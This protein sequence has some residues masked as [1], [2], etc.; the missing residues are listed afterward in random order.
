MAVKR[1]TFSGID[2]G[3]DPEWLAE[4]TSIYSDSM[5]IEWGILLSNKNSRPR[6]PGDKWIESLGK[7]SRE[8]ELFLAGH[9][10]GKYA[11]D[12]VN[13]KLETE[14]D[15]GF[16]DRIQINFGPF[17]ELV[18]AENL[19]NSIVEQQQQDS[20]FILQAGKELDKT[21]EIARY[22]KKRLI[23]TSI[24]FDCSGGNGIEPQSWPQSLPDI[25]CGYAGG[26]APHN[27]ERQLQ[28]IYSAAG[29][30][31]FWIDMESGIR[32]HNLIDQDKII[33]VIN[34]SKRF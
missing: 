28:E 29:A 16:F 5:N 2:E 9:L 21:I 12:F 30:A 19:Y 27:L 32:T 11:R 13:G 7:L 14:I 20:H 31:Q 26:L 18:S 25:L 23:Q 1:I 34:I 10:C 6:Y 33:E 17:I 22:L 15:L 24:L 4:I 8:K 3:I